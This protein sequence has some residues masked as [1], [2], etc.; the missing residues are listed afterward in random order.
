MCNGYLHQVIE[1]YFGDGR[2]WGVEIYHSNEKKPLGTAGALSNIPKKMLK[3][4][5]IIFL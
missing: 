5:F 1:D 2:K 4:T 3:N